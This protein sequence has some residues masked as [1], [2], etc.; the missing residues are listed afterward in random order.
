[1]SVIYKARFAQKNFAWKKDKK[2]KRLSEKNSNQS[3]A[4]NNISKLCQKADLPELCSE[5]V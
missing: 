4:P 5:E 1:M 3:Y 2:Q